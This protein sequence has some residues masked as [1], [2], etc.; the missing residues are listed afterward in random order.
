MYMVKLKGGKS[1]KKFKLV[2]PTNIFKEIGNFLLLKLGGR[3]LGVIYFYY[4]LN[5]MFTLY[6]F[7][8]IYIDISKISLKKAYIHVIF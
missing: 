7:L 8:C 6:T 4:H 5:C 3:Y 1:N 2:Q